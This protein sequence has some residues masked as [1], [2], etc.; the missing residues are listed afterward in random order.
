M[1]VSLP[2]YKIRDNVYRSSGYM[3]FLLVF[4]YAASA[5]RAFENDQNFSLLLSPGAKQCVF[6]TLAVAF[7]MV[8][9]MPE[10]QPF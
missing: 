5:I 3:F 8:L 2:Q 10:V 6:E 1:I 7:C 9:S 4:L